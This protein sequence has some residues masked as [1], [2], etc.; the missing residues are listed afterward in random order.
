MDCEVPEKLKC[1]LQDFDLWG[2]P[3]IDN[4]ADRQNMMVEARGFQ[5]DIHGRY[6]EVC[7]M[8]PSGTSASMFCIGVSPLTKERLTEVIYKVAWDLNTDPPFVEGPMVLMNLRDGFSTIREDKAHWIFD[9]DSILIPHGPNADGKLH[10]LETFAGGF[11]GWHLASSFITK[12]CQTD[13]RTIA[14]EENMMKAIQWAVAHNAVLLEAMTT[15]PDIDA[16]HFAHD[17]ILHADIEGRAWWKFIGT[18]GVDLLLVSSPCPPWSTASHSPGLASDVGCLLPAALLLAR[19]FKPTIICIEQV[20]GFSTH[21]HKATCLRILRHMGYR[22]HWSKIVDS[23]DF[24]GITRLRWL[25]IAYK[26][27]DTEVEPTRFIPFPKVPQMTPK[28]L[29]TVFPEVP[30]DHD[31]LVVNAEMLSVARDPTMVPTHLKRKLNHMLD[32]DLLKLRTYSADQVHPT[33]MAMYG[34][35]H[36]INPRF[37]QSKGYMGSFFQPEEG[38]LRLLH[39]AEIAMSHVCFGHVVIHKQFREAWEVQGNQ[40]TMPHSLLLLTNSLCMI[41]KLQT[42]DI[43][44]IFHTLLSKHMQV[45]NIAWF[46]SEHL[47]MM[48]P[49][50]SVDETAQL[51]LHCAEQ[52][53]TQDMTFGMPNNTAWWPTTGIQVVL[54]PPPAPYDGMLSQTTVIDLTEEDAEVEPTQSFAPMVKIRVV[55]GER[56]TFF[57]AEG[58]LAPHSICAQFR[59]CYVAHDTPGTDD[60]CSFE[61]R[62]ANGVQHS[63]P[64]DTILVCHDDSQ[65]TMIQIDDTVPVATTLE[66]KHASH[67]CF[68]QFGLIDPTTLFHSDMMVFD[69]E[70]KPVSEGVD[71]FFLLAAYQLSDMSIQWRP[72][73]QDLVFTFVGDQ[74]EQ[75]TLMNFWSSLFEADEFQKLHVQMSTC[76]S[77]DHQGNLVSTLHYTGT[78]R[79]LVPDHFATLLSVLAT[80]KVLNGQNWAEGKDVCI[81][82]CKRNLWGPALWSQPDAVE[83]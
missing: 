66:H 77:Y 47:M 62:Q 71:T 70:I 29:N 2:H 10:V 78:D 26:A 9:R 43:D 32:Q 79:P 23:A 59:D 33:I 61:L 56:A 52:L 18:W 5:V 55:E 13:M 82:W 54:M 83:P 80:R 22:L 11:G 19:I 25:A 12:L 38:D 75:T 3:G 48:V 53:W 81:R 44:N 36:E 50:E 1:L 60:A 76:E 27:H 58:T 31:K 73:A 40:I 45:G 39:P 34:A 17:M 16:D 72:Q 42:S 6:L 4:F 46:E 14:I 37:M 67:L 41:G 15:M 51:R 69:H 64:S 65:T 35:Q 63:S 30:P 28:T 74:T 57:W 68:D 20:S 49:H 8:V 21:K 24:G 7:A